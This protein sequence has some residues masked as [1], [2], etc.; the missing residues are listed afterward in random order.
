MRDGRPTEP[1]ESDCIPEECPVCKRD[2]ADEEGELLFP[3]G[4]CSELCEGKA[5]HGSY[6][7]RGADYASYI[8]D[9]QDGVYYSVG[10]GPDGWYLTTVVDCDTGHFVDTMDD[11]DGPYESELEATAGG[12]S[13]GTEWCMF[14][15]VNFLENEVE[16][17]EG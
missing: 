2:N 5:E 3:S 4:H 9:E 17:S 10:Q 7:W 1:D 8:G 16:H 11:D 6:S 14:N 13:A 12:Q 15:E